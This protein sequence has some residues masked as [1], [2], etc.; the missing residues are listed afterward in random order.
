MTT[1]YHFDP[2]LST[3]LF[4]EFSKSSVPLRH[5]DWTNSLGM[6][7]R[8]IDSLSLWACRT[9][10]R[11]GDF[12]QFVTNT[13]YDATGGMY[14]I[15]TNGSKQANGSWTTP[16]FPQTDDYPVVGVNWSD[17][18]TSARGSPGTSGNSGGLTT[19]L[20]YRL[21]TTNAWFAVSGR[22]AISL[23]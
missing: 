20:F 12:R 4:I 21:P 23:G 5:E 14:S 19:N 18:T 7:F 16:G 2:S 22:A 9:E 13:L 6:S 3:N 15:T 10:T 11:V 17:A 8:W 1:N